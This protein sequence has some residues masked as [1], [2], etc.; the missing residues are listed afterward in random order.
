MLEY[1]CSTSVS[2]RSIII[3][4]ALLACLNFSRAEA[5]QSREDIKSQVLKAK[6]LREKG[7]F[8]EA[9]RIYQSLL[10]EL[11]AQGPSTELGDALIGLGQI[12]N[13]EGHYQDAI[14]LAQESAQVFHI[15]GSKNGE[16]RARNDAGFAFMN[17]GKYREATRE[18]D[19]ALAL[20][21]Q[22]GVAG[23]PVF[24]LNTLGS[25]YYYRAEYSEAFRAYNTALQHVE[26]HAAES[27]APYWRQHTLL[28]L[29]TLY[30]RIGDDQR[31]LAVYKQLEQSTGPVTQGYRGHLYANLGVLY[32]HLG[33]PQKALDAY[34]KAKR[35][36]ALEHDVDGE[37]GV[38]KNTGIVLAL[39]LGRL[40]NALTTFGTA[41][42]LA[43]KSKNRREA[44]QASLYS[45]ETLFRMG[46]L[47]LAKRQL[48]TALSEAISLG[49]V[50]EQWKALYALGKIAE[51]Q[52]QPAVAEA[53]YRD[54][55]SRIESVRSKIQLS[56]LKS[57]FLAD[58][59]DVYD[60]IIRL[61]LTRN[62]LPAAF[63][64]MERSRARVFQDRFYSGERP[65]VTTSLESIKKMIDPSTAVVEFWMAPGTIA[66]VWVT[67][68]SQG[69]AKRD[70]GPTEMEAVTRMIGGLPET[71][72]ESWK[73]GAEKLTGLMPAGIVPF[74]DAR[75]IH[76]LIVAD[77]LLSL[78]PFELLSS[79]LEEPLLA[80]HDVS[81]LPSAVL[82]LRS[83]A[84][85]SPRIQLPWR[86][87][88]IAFGD[89]AL[90]A[91][92]GDLL[93]GAETQQNGILPGSAAEIGQIK[94]MTAGRS[95]IF[96]G[97]A[98]RKQDFLESVHQGAALLHISTHAIADMD[99][100][101][102]SRLLFS[103]NQPGEPNTYLFLK[104][105]YDLDL[106]GVSLATLSA[107]DTEKGKLV[108]GE[109]IQAFS[110]ALLAAG[111]QSAL[112]TLWRVPDGPTAQFMH[113]FY[114]F[115][116]KKHKPKAEALRLAKLEFAHSQT[117]LSHPRYW[118]AFVLNGNGA[119]PVPRFV[120][121]QELLL[122]FPVIVLLALL[123]LRLRK[124]M[125][126]RRSVII[127]DIRASAGS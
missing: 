91:S 5:W 126:Q 75:Y 78:F 7:A 116:L 53:E 36:Y 30:Q 49:T 110:R 107:C 6:T 4:V 80:K 17:A 61:L 29:A 76:I 93:A 65:S 1:T 31:A 79:N 13:A 84:E 82:L 57:D 38:L 23:T 71:L 32:R 63:E 25:V 44:M 92:K 127:S 59:R 121:W 109:G 10:P 54:A 102:R 108:Q 67:R 120:S 56:V 11:R 64:Y 97:A 69:L 122:P 28:N 73:T 58:K 22:G 112:T 90:T 8:Q 96:L 42:A 20:G 43:I 119:M 40:P 24:I 45:A 27:W 55:I 50:E 99:D 106:R 113:R 26:Q 47:P 21:Y 125:S 114:F 104:E 9:H 105:L 15:L 87:Q 98:D 118:A 33:D 86:Q 34:L 66:A 12:A 124:T 103:P 72:G 3:A 52:G 70:L 95:R 46:R 94:H 111:S 123:L 35:A 74:S 39:N 62:D 60:G 19:L 100:P 16:A 101:E 89:P 68:D 77:G 37:L 85:R 88:L 81:Y 115:L 2:I 51:A 48:E 18:L 83:A 41:R 117:R 14:A